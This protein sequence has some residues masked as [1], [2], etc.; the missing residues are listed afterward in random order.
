MWWISAR[1]RSRVCPR[2]ESP[3]VLLAPPAL[4]RRLGPRV[5]S[6]WCIECGWR[7]LVLRR[8]LPTPL[9]G[10]GT[11]PGG[12]PRWSSVP[13]SRLRLAF[14][15]KI[16]PRPAE[17]PSLSDSKQGEDPVL[18]PGKES[19]PDPFRWG[20]PQ[21]GDRRPELT[22]RPRDSAPLSFPVLYSKEE[23]PSAPNGPG[24]T[25]TR[26]RP[27]RIPAFFRRTVRRLRNLSRFPFS[28]HR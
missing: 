16:R 10:R 3:T 7:G 5:N 12:A 23:S 11:R 25:P 28:R 15:A 14:E 2:C 20:P 24:A 8:I 26:R 6:R 13:P 17:T 4:F 9:P 1:S 22:R 19:L 21:R 27:A 18:E